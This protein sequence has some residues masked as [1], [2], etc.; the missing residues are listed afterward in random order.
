VTSAAIVN[1]AVRSADLANG[2]VIESKLDPAVVSS[3]TVH[4]PAGL[5][6]AG[7]ICVEADLRADASYTDALSTCARAQLRLPDPGELA[8]AFDHLGASQPNQWVAA[9]V[10]YNDDL[11][12]LG[13]A[14]LMGS[15]ASRT[16]TTTESLA[17]FTF[18][19][20]CVT[21]ASNER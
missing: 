1:G 2:A 3:L 15:T 18:P 13:N 5:H 7:D 19:Y 9:G 11:A 4:C 16:I 17:V 21:S 8:L 14:A 20:R 12:F 10:D 6:Q